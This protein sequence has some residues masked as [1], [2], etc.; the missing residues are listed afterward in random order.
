MVLGGMG[1]GELLRVKDTLKKACRE[2]I[3]LWCIDSTP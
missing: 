2:G 1:V 3:P